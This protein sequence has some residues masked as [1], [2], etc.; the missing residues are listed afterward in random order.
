MNTLRVFL[1]DLLW[2]QDSAGFTRRIETFL[3]IA[4]K[5]HVHPVFVLFDSCWEPEPKLGPE[6][7]PIPGVHNSGWVQSP[8]QPTLK[9]PSQ[10]PR[11]KDWPLSLRNLQ[12]RRP[13]PRQWRS[14]RKCLDECACVSRTQ[15]QLR[16]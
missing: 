4:D 8:G 7:P 6:N 12:V 11:L 10:Y 3:A 5:H 1:H 9:N 13:A 14:R 16:P 2:Q 15:P